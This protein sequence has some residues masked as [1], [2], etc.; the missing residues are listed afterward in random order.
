MYIWFFVCVLGVIAVMPV[1]FLSVEHLKL[2]DRYGEEKGTSIGKIFGV[3][4]GWGF[5]SFGLEYGFRHRLDS[6][7]QSY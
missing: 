3:V 2:Q 7:F 4:S 1:H 5:F 6:Q